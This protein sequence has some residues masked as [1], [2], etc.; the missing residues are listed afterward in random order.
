MPFSIY[1]Y[2]NPYE[3]DKELYWDSI[4]NCPHF[5]VS[6]TMANGIMGTYTDMTAGKVSTVENL[7]KGL[8]S[9]W[10]S[11]ECKIKQ[12]AD[13]DWAI[14]ELDIQD[15]AAKVRQSLRFNRKGLSNSL[16]I[17]FELDMS[18]DDMRVDLMSE[19]QK[20][21]VQLYR[22]I[23]KSE[24]LND[25]RL[26]RKFSKEEIE[27]AI[28]QGMLLG[29]DGADLSSV[30]IDSIV[31]HGVHQFSPMI[32]QTLEII[33]KYKRV[34]LLFNYQQQYKNVYQTWIDVYSSFDLPIKSQ[35]INEF[36]P[37]PLLSN[38][39]DGN[40]LAERMANLVE[41]RPE[42]NDM[43]VPFEIMEFDNNTEFASYVAK[44]YEDAMK[45]QEKDQHGKR[46]ALYYMKEQ[47][48]AANNSVNNIL[49]I[50][51]PG[52]F[53]ERHFLTYPIG[54]FF[55]SITNMWN[56]DEGG[57]RIENMNDIVECLNS[58]FVKEKVPGSLYAIFNKTN[59]FFIRAESIEEIVELLGK[60]RKR[61]AKAEK[62]ANEKRIGRRLIYFDVTAEEIDLLIDAL[63]QLNKITKVFYEDFEDAENNFKKFYKKIKEFLETRLL[64]AEDLE[65]EFRDVVKR[66]LIRLEEVDNIDASGSFD[67]LKE[68][69]S[70]Y[71]KQESKKGVSAN[72]IV[73]DFEQ[74]DGD[75]LK[76][77]HQYK[78]TVYHFASLSDN[79]MNVTNRDRFP[80]P[81]D[82]NFFEVAQDPIDWKYQVYVKSRR[83]Y[84]N[85]KRY[86]LIYGLQF[87]RVKFKLS[88]VKNVDDKENEM[89]YLFKILQASKTF[90]ENSIGN[91]SSVQKRD[92]SLEIDTTANY[93]QY[94][95]SRY[96][97]CKYRFL[98]E[99]TIEK[100]T[101][102][103]DHFL[104]LKYLEILL[105]NQ[106]RVTLQG[107]IATEDI[108]LETLNDELKKLERKFEFV[109]DMHTERMD[110][111]TNAKNYLLKSVL[112]NG[113]TF[114]N[115]TL[116]D[117]TYMKKRE[118]FIY[119]QL[120][121]G[122][123][124]FYNNFKDVSQSE[125][126]NRLGSEKVNKAGYGKSCDEWCQY[127][128]VREICMEPYRYTTNQ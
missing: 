64:E 68:T 33:S 115:V 66:V 5:C 24:R 99:S 113:S 124:S 23:Q 1:T 114:P 10:E 81:L 61:I 126:D 36:K 77:Q 6:Q 109:R 27:E 85:F 34:V 60:L 45:R 97:I 119:L 25:F 70:Y 116:N 103:R 48:Y 19:E 53:G 57:I 16:R 75:I 84:K 74:I 127:C 40:L 62:D 117:E 122:D 59:E 46:S 88:Y 67:V 93:G 72:W 3:I 71:L 21:L 102:Y 50:Y 120:G 51:Y 94:D 118:E 43:E 82:V 91:V 55:L 112:K 96:K 32:L 106:A 128:A 98:L 15:N 89:F 105:E 54:H 28:K 11:S 47:F 35:F 18:L 76:S 30:D 123:N 14:G 41:G 38:S 100:R 7:V 4:K 52:Q 29:R 58:G 17:L 26:K 12:Y 104:L 37:N 31:V 78:D 86:A 44:V 9:Y 56:P 20:H 80:W 95:Y 121:N 8:F 65:D 111:I 73:R 90:P 101:V 22:L 87:N 92:C 125:I 108:L 49:K 39:Y 79:D 110:A 13:I 69:M 2:S 42:E 107:Q 63:E 83:E